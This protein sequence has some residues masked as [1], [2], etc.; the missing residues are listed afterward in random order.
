MLLIPCPYCGDRPE[1]EFTYGGEAHV[2][3]PADAAALSDQEWSDFLYMRSNPKGV[4]A[5][6][7]RHVHGCA[8]FFNVLRDTRDDH[9]QAVYETGEARP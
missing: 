1:L 7:W 6:R 5:E 2:S 9:I 3:R 4:H 8:R